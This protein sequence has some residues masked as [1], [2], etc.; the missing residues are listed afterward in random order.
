MSAS[1]ATDELRERL[2]LIADVQ[3]A[4]AL[5]AWDQETYMPPGA[6]EARA[7]QLT[8]LARIAHEELV[9]ERVGELLEAAAAEADGEPYDSDAASL[10]RVARRDRDR[11]IR[12]PADLVARLARAASLGQQAWQRARQESDFAAFR[13]H[14]ERLVDLTLEK[15]ETLGYEDH[16]YDPLLDEFEP[17]MTT[18]QLR[19]LFA[20]LRERLVPIVQA[21]TEPGAG[22][23]AGENG[24]SAGATGTSI[25]GAG[26]AAGPNAVAAA[27][28]LRQ[29]FDDRGQWELGL[30]V[31]RDF[32]FDFA[33]GRQDRS[34]HPFSTAFATTDVRLTTRIH[35]D[36]LP[37]G[38]FGSMHECGHGLYE[39]G[40]APELDRTPLA[41]GASLGV[42]ESQS[43]L[44]EILVGRSRPFWRHYYPR[45]QARFPEQLGGVDR[46]DF[47]RAINTV[48]PTLIRVEAD[49]VTY[50]LHIMLRFELEVGLLEGG[51]S[52]PDLPEAWNAGMES[53]LG[54]VPGNDAE[55][56]LQDIHW[57]MGAI[58]YFPTYT[59]GN[60]M[61]A[62]IFA[63]A[64]R[65]IP[66]LDERTA[67]GD[68][69]D[70]H[71]WL[72]DNIYRH[73]RKLTSPELLERLGCGPLS[74]EPW[75]EH[76][77]A[78]YGELYGRDL[79]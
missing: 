8:T 49:E 69:A 45:L 1:P 6:I 58:G 31:M 37:A 41:G 26:A 51:I 66:D 20:M 78:K 13:P 39:Q 47:Y 50:N 36:F 4:A 35:E 29:R 7:A 9:A 79:P 24:G 19:P 27:G 32:G 5:L 14:L 3:A 77:R 10:V 68:F 30:E 21:L 57:S 28:P 43:R 61:S 52:V 48:A 25:G 70:L 23:G 33:R 18:A 34:A 72:R 76:I 17:G 55:G 60:V 59:L 38:L 22:G 62:Q 75:L 63:G 15:A 46:E 54:I 42:H 12:L 16:V 71:G 74:A 56:V 44:W 65:A 67:A 2:G 53:Y 40:V 73:G 11:A 64:R